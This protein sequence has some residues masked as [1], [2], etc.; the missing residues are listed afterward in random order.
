MTTSVDKLF[1][2]VPHLP[3]IPKVVQALI[4]SLNDDE[5]DLSSLVNQ[6]KQD[7]SLSA[8]VLRLANSSY[9]G[10]SYKIGAI[11]DAITLIGLNA[12][13]T[14]VIASG[15]AGAFVK[16]EGIDLKAFWR[17]S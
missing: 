10:A 2:S 14:L 17:H 4:V 16:V 5:A 7:Q 1:A 13:R 3:S 8:R 15:V 12:L 11:E 9:Y 6:V